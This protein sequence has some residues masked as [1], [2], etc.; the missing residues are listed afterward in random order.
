MVGKLYWSGKRLL[1]RV[2]NLIET[3]KQYLSSVA[4]SSS[5][6]AQRKGTTFNKFSKRETSYYDQKWHI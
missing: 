5:S 2:Y 4:L 1:Y 3:T 6:G